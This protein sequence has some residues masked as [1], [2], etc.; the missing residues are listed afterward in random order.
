MAKNIG[1]LHDNLNTSIV[2]YADDVI[3]LSPIDKHLQQLLLICEKYAEK[4]NIKFN[5]KNRV[6]YLLILNIKEILTFVIISFEI[7]F[8][9]MNKFLFL[10]ENEPS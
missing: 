9:F 6:F 7:F 1:A 8:H 3:L 10:N 4:W 2:M 5:T